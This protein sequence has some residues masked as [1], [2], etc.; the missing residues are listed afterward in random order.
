MADADWYS[1]VGQRVHQHE[2]EQQRHEHLRRRDRDCGWGF[3]IDR[4]CA[5]ANASFE[6]HV[7]LTEQPTRRWT[8]PCWSTRPSAGR[9]TCSRFR[10]KYSN[11]PR[12]TRMCANWA[13]GF[14]CP[15][16]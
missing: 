14:S 11:C 9:P 1:A 3:A 13:W 4:V 8:A 15:H 5:R 2:L 10:A 7:P 16:P 6:T 12:I